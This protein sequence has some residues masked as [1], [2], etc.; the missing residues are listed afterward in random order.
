MN[1]LVIGGTG[2]VGSAVVR[3]LVARG[4][5]VR[6][7]TRNPAAAR[8]PAGV[9]A[10]RGDL[11]DPATVRSVFDGHDGVFMLNPVSTTE[12]HEGLMGVLGAAAA[13]VGRFVYLTIHRLETTPY[14]PHF[15]SKRPVE[16][17]VR[18][19]GLRWTI[20]RPNNFFQN[21]LWCRAALLEHGV[22]PQP[23]GSA[24]LSRIDVR[25]IAE[26]AAIAL[27]ASGSEHEHR[28][29]ELAGPES[30]TAPAT[31]AIWAEALDREVAYG[32]D[33]LDAWEAAACA[34][35]PAWMAYDFRQMYSWFQTNGLVATDREV[36]A[37]TALLGHA[38]RRFRD[39][40]RET[41]AQWLAPAGPDSSRG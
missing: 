4:A 17:A 36:A 18:E 16:Q 24:G 1:T 13:G 31:A 8:L 40:A 12:T 2:T 33:D 7:L 3:E 30:L 27:T 25:D 5:G 10:V 28:T 15:A 21:D 32:G 34:Q 22:Y 14:L 11:L 29:Y 35:L 6:V 20:L 23:F 39:F 26:A 38:P 19:S 9:E 41:A 37:L